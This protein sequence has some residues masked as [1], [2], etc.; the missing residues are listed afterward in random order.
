[1]KILVTGGS[2]FIGSHIADKFSEKGHKVIIFDKQNSKWINKKQNITNITKKEKIIDINYYDIRKSLYE[3]KH[4]ICKNSQIIDIDNDTKIR[5]HDLDEAIKLAC[6]NYKSA[7]TNL[8][9]DKIKHF[10][11]RYWKHTKKIKTMDLE[12]SNFKCNTIRKKILGNVN[13]IYN[14]TLFDFNI[15]HDCKL[16]YN[17]LTDEYTL[18]VPIEEKKDKEKEFNNNIV[19][20]DPGIRTFLSGI[21]DNTI[22]K[23]GDNS[24]R[25]I[26][27]Y[28]KRI[29]K[30]NNNKEI[31][32]NKKKKLE[33]KYNKKIMN[34]TDEIHWKS[35]NYLTKNYKSILIGNMS[36][37]QIV[38]NSRRGGLTS[39]TKRICNMYRFYVFRRRLMD[40]CN[41]RNNN[42]KCVNESYTSIIC[43]VCGAEADNLG[44]K[45]VY[46]CRSCNIKLDRDINGARNIYLKSA[47]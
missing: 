17:S 12:K 29:D 34:Y 20:L 10:R 4:K 7:I 21:S 6:T 14:G 19:S 32:K 41:K 39:M 26:K 11:I 27:Y 15:K 2:G 44:S 22:I 8:Q 23:I 46:N 36:S 3:S 47:M 42:Y 38:S 31:P 30:I 9:K 13:G 16:S 18:Y 43:S 24:Q 5:I 33:R 37:K 25:K 45:R 40:K 28:L 1:M 35:I